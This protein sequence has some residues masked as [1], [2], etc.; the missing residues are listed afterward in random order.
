[1]SLLC[2]LLLGPLLRQ[3]QNHFED[4][5]IV[6]A[7]D[8][9]SSLS[10]V[11]DSTL[12]ASVETQLSDLGNVLSRDFHVVYRTL[13][14]DEEAESLGNSGFAHPESPLANLLSD[15]KADY[16]GRNL[17][18]VVLASDGIY[19]QGPS[20]TFDTYAYPIHT[21]GLGDTI[22]KRDLNLQAVFYNQIAYQGNRFPLV[23]EISNEGF[24]GNSTQ[25]QVIQNGQVLAS[26]SIS[27]AGPSQVQ[28]VQ[29]LLDATQEGLQRYTVRV[30]PLA[31]EFTTQNNQ[32]SV[33]LDIVEGREKVLIAAASPHPDIKAI[34]A[35]LEKNANYEITTFIPGLNDWEAD[36]YDVVILHQLPSARIG[37]PVPVRRLLEEGASTWF[38][39]GSQTNMQAFNQL[40]SVLEVGVRG[41]QRDQVT[42]IFQPNFA[43]FRYSEENQGLT[44]RYPPV[45]VPF[46]GVALKNAGEVLFYQRVGSIDTNKPLWVFSTE[47]DNKQAVTLGSGLW[48][49]R[50]QEYARTENQEAFDELVS[51]TVQYLSS[52]EDR[53]KFK[54]Y[55]ISNEFTESQ[56]VILE[57]EV[58][59]DIYEEVYDQNIA[60]S[61]RREGGDEITYSYTTS[62]ANTRYRISG[63]EEG[64]YQFSA[65]T[66]VDGEILTS[67]GA[68]TIKDLQLE[69]LNLTANHALLRTLSEDTGGLYTTDYQE[70]SNQLSNTPAQALIHTSEQF[71]PLVNLPWVFFL[72]LV[73]LTLEWV[74]RRYYGSY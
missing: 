70:L 72:V 16:E 61:L 64:I 57:T 14:E 15:I 65:T 47:E 67:T 59:N 40:N 74:V 39:W 42:P 22:P 36:K 1:V 50:L 73:L 34:R 17:A 29:F 13:G 5:T 31:E 68:F 20:P 63:L 53:R 69:S 46:G 6:I 35:A 48:Q 9:S 38:I 4:P 26:Q 49:W 33:Y 12:L 56:P 8:D 18:A 43:R 62:A 28:E 7:L 71:L 52:K 19:N 25:V 60:L 54:V 24:A 51:K 41:N 2:F 32:R 66:S 11:T 3:I 55:P 23:A 27:F 44:N 21:L 58:Y 30:S 45:T 37:I 10:Q